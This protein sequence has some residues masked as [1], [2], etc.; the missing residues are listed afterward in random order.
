M[1]K[2]NPEKGSEF[3]ASLVAMSRYALVA[4]RFESL[5]LPAPFRMATG[6]VTLSSLRCHAHMMAVFVLQYS[7][8]SA[9]GAKRR[10]AVLEAN[11]R[12]CT[13][14]AWINQSMFDDGVVE[15]K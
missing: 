12:K 6:H 3:G 15:A 10:K 11:K 9:R 14:L 4:G 13:F 7:S 8:V 1:Q 5:V 2:R